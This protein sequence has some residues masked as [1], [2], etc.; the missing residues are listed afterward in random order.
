MTRLAIAVLAA[1]AQVAS[2]KGRAHSPLQ[3]LLA[4]AYRANGEARDARIAG[5][6]EAEYLPRY[7]VARRLYEQ[8]IA[9]YPQFDD[10]YDVQYR[11]GEVLYFSGHPRESLPHYHWL[12]EHRELGKRVAELHHWID[13]TV[14]AAESIIVVLEAECT[15]AGPVVSPTKDQLAALRRPIHQRVLPDVCVQLIAAY[16]R[17]AA[18]APDAQYVPMTALNAAVIS[19][20]Y[21]HVAEARRRFKSVM[22]THCHTPVAIKARDGL[23]V[24]DLADGNVDRSEKTERLFAKL[25]CDGS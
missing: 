19:I 15:K 18:I 4:A 25:G 9:S 1:C 11:L 13:H 2:A 20:A 16:D 3:E 21:L 12:V 24:L 6:P 8:I 22:V 17:Y 14:E 10:V 23:R 5:K 7:E